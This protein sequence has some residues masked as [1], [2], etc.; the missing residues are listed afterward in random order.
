MTGPV[1]IYARISLD[2]SDD[3]AGVKR[4][5]SACRA[6]AAQRGLEVANV[7]VDNSISASS[8]RTRPAF[9]RLLIERPGTVIVWHLDRLLRKSS[10]DLERVLDLGATVHS[11]QGG[12]FD[13]STPTGRALAR[14]VVAWSQNEVELKGERQ[15]AAN[16]ERALSGRVYGRKI[17]W[18]WLDLACTE[19]DADAAA[20]IV[21][22]V[23]D[24]IAGKSLTEVAREWIAAGLVA[25]GGKAWLPATVRTTLLRPMNAG[26]VTY[27]DEEYRDVQAQ[28]TPLFD[29]A[30]YDALRAVLASR[31]ITSGTA[32]VKATSYLMGGLARCGKCG[33][34]MQGSVQKSGVNY[35]C[36]GRVHGCYRAI[37]VAAL[38]QFVIRWTTAELMLDA[39]PGKHLSEVAVARLSALD[40]DLRQM[41]KERQEVAQ[42]ALSVS[43]RAALLSEVDRRERELRAEVATLSQASAVYALVRSLTEPQEDT[44]DA[45]LAT[46]VEISE[47]L[48]AL[49]S[50]QLRTVVQRYGTYVV[51]G[52]GDRPRVVCVPPQVP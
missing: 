29:V 22:A 14:T 44:P 28:W 31:S 33:S 43:S 41:A 35:L 34:T 3:Q 9:E 15:R 5:E 19:V 42:T 30:T 48:Q 12:D 10:R 20:V 17:P 25:P 8:G 4:Q 50:R 26:I 2:P 47:R 37:R 32:G 52:R 16:R 45:A 13:L 27:H 23:Q 6:W 21:R 36:S 7:Y 18:G 46:A 40:G 49:P 38:D 24:V 51:G 11:L 1:A 39:D